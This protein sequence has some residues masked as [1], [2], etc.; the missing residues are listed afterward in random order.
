METIKMDE[1]SLNQAIEK[2]E[3][4]SIF[5]ILQIYKNRNVSLYIRDILKTRI[6]IHKATFFHLRE[7]RIL[8]NR[9]ARLLSKFK[10]PKISVLM[11]V[12]TEKTNDN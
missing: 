11:K 12:L 1:Y 3:K 8:F 6:K 9:Q 5:I 2:M 4:D 10:A 7:M